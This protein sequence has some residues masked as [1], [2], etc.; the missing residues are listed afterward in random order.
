MAVI[1]KEN[2]APQKINKEA[3]AKLALNQRV[4]S[5]LPVNDGE[6][7]TFTGNYFQRNYVVSGSSNPSTNGEKSMVLLELSNGAKTIKVG[8]TMFASRSIYG[9]AED[10]NGSLESSRSNI[11]SEGTFANG[12]EA[13]DIF[14]GIKKNDVFVVHKHPYAKTAESNLRSNVIAFQKK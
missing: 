8:L 12:T 7:W 14:N 6:E 13:M 4:N 2:G 3:A 11:T 10:N 5:S 1:F 9:F